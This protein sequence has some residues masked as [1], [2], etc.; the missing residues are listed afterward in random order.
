MKNLEYIPGDFV[1][2]NGKLCE[3]VGDSYLGS[4]FIKV[5][6]YVH[7]SFD[8]N[9][10]IVSKSQE[11]H[12]I[13]LTD[14]ILKAN[15]KIIHYLQPY[16]IYMIGWISLHPNIDDYKNRI[17]VVCANGEKI[18]PPIQFVHQLQHLLFGLGV[19]HEMEVLVWV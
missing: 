8:N 18:M 2:A 7:G 6:E 11:I 9:V 5:S 16:N 10:Y 17:F 19:N 4:D 14:E 3:V 1:F 13:P 15:D 12:G